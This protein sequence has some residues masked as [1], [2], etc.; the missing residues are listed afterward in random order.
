M[1]NKEDPTSVLTK[2]TQDYFSP[3]AKEHQNVVVP[4]SDG[5]DNVKS[6][7]E[8]KDLESQSKES[9]SPN[10]SS[11]LFCGTPQKTNSRRQPFITLEKYSGGKSPCPDAATTFSGPLIKANDG[12]ERCNTSGAVSSLTT[13]SSPGPDSQDSSATP[14]KR[15]SNLSFK[16][17]PSESPVRPRECGTTCEPTRLIE[18]LSSKA[19]DA[20]DVEPETQIE[21]EGKE[22]EEMASPM[23]EESLSQEEKLDDSQSSMTITPSGEPRRSGRHRVRPSRPGEDSKEPE[24]KPVHPKR[25]RSQEALKGAS[26]KLSLAQSKPNTRKRPTSEE[27]N[28]KERLRT[29]AQTGQTESSQTDSQGR[30]PKRVKLYSSSQDF[31]D[32]VEPKRRSTRESSQRD[33]QPEMHTDDKSQSQ[34]RSGRKSKT[35]LPTKE[36]KETEEKV[37]QDIKES[38]QTESP[39][40]AEDL[41]KEV[42]P[43]GASQTVSPS[44]E[45]SD[46]TQE[47]E[48]GELSKMDEDAKEDSQNTTTKPGTQSQELVSSGTVEA[49]RD[50]PTVAVSPTDIPNTMESSDEIQ[51]QEDSKENVLLS[52][53][54]QSLRRSRRSKASSETE[55]S[56]EKRKNNKS[57]RLSRSSSQV[58]SPANSQT[59][60]PAEGRGRRS[61]QLSTPENSQSAHVAGSAESSNETG[62][63]SSRRSSQASQSKMNSSAVE[64][65][66]PRAN[67]PVPKKRGRKPKVCTP[68]PLGPE[69]N[70]SMQDIDQSSIN[71]SELTQDCT[72]ESNLDDSQSKQD[73]PLPE[74]SAEDPQST[75]NNPVPESNVDDLKPVE[76]NPLLESKLDHLPTQQDFQ[77][78]ESLEE[79]HAAMTDE[80]EPPTAMDCDS[81]SA[82][83][84]M[85]KQTPNDSNSGIGLSRDNDPTDLQTPE[86]HETDAGQGKVSQEVSL[87]PDK[88]K[89]SADVE[90]TLDTEESVEE[91]KESSSPC[92]AVEQKPVH[93]PEDQELKATDLTEVTPCPADEGNL[94]DCSSVTNSDSKDEE[95]ACVTEGTSPS[96]NADA[97]DVASQVNQEVGTRTVE[98][99]DE[100]ETRTDDAKNECDAAPLEVRDASAFAA[101]AEDVFLDSPLKQ[102]D[103]DSLMGQDL[104]QSPSSRTRGTW[105]PSA[106]PSTSILKKG[107]KRPLEDQTPSPLVKV[108]KE[109]H[110]FSR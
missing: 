98:C 31:L 60:T 51:S 73:N 21:T 74:C 78:S 49:K 85:D 50:S 53:D 13:E 79:T 54:G 105:S 99:R 72:P 69:S 27:D 40:Q 107:Q 110:I 33:L 66:E 30:T 109:R 45:K 7:D 25:T 35:S 55:E 108:N 97:T 84:H 86:R 100:E 8:S 82:S 95:P 41:Q 81:P 29:R 17:D 5:V 59:K 71:D 15:N 56:D 96:W 102:K 76:D 46:S 61:T 43:K 83:P 91:T 1:D 70:L 38:T 58:S 23:E 9:A 12:Q 20:D 90:M 62:R 2:D 80:V 42:E 37:S 22:N 4:E 10:T 68:N 16:S 34:G 88:D 101:V 18:R 89:L 87:S 64:S 39:Q 63:Y 47:R 48:V 103:I 44:L 106:S 32:A 36:E 3:N 93:H 19:Q 75:E 26:Q 77:G 14:K 92:N 6:D 94:T 52:H 67:V 65:S 24:E 104:G 11:D 28:G 57:T